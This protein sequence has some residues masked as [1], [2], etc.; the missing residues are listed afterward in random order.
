MDRRSGTLATPS[1]YGYLRERVRYDG[2][3][4]LLDA[5]ARGVMMAW[6]RARA[7]GSP[8][9]NTC[10]LESCRDPHDGSCRG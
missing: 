4:A 5:D 2:D 8:A 7:C 1:N 9:F 10:L 3:D 6:E